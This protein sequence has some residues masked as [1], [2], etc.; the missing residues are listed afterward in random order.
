M[1][2]NRILQVIAPLL[3]AL[4]TS[5]RGDHFSASWLEDNLGIWQQDGVWS[6]SAYP[7]NGHFI[8]DSN[9][10]PVPGPNPTYDVVLGIS[11]PCT[12]TAN[13]QIQT[14]NV[15][16]GATLNLGNQGYLW[17]NTGFGNAGLI[18]LNSTG[19]FSGLLRASANSNVVNGGIIFMSD[20]FSNSVTAGSTGKV[21]TI[22]P[23]GTIRGAGAINEYHGDDRRTFFQIVNHGLI[24][25]MQP[26]NALRVQLTNDPAFAV[27]MINDGTLRATGP[28]V[29][30]ISTLGTLENVSNDGGII[31]AIDTGTVRLKLDATVTGGTLATSGNGTIRGDFPNSSGGTFNNVLNTGIMAVGDR[32]N[33][34]IAGTFTN[35]GVV[36][37]DGA[38]ELS[39][40]L[41][42]RGNSVT[43]T[44]TGLIA[45][46]G[47]CGIGGGDTV[48]QTAIISPGFT[49]RGRGTIGTDN[50]LYL[51]KALNVVNQGLIDATGPLTIFVRADQNSQL[52]NDG[53]T[54]RASNGGVLNFNCG[55]SGGLVLNS[56]GTVEALAGST[57]RVNDL[58]TL[59]G[60]TITTSGTGVIRGGVP[61]RGG[62]LKNVTSTGTVAI[63]P[64]EFLHLADTFTNNG[65]VRF[66]GTPAGGASLLLRNDVT[67]AGTGVF[68]MDGQQAGIAG[69]DVVGRTMTVAPA[70][71]IRGGGTIGVFNSNFA[72]KILNVVNQGLIE[73]TTGL[74]IFVRDNQGSNV[75]NNA[76]TLRAAPGSVLEF[77][78]AGTVANNNGGIVEALSN[79]TIQF[80]NGAA[81]INNAG[82]TIGLNG[83]TI[84]AA[85][86][87]DL[88]GGQLIGNGTF[89]GPI[90][91]NGGSVAPGFSA[92]KI[93]INGNYTQGANGVLNM[94]IGG[95][96]PGTGY[97]QLQVSG[98]A[99]LGGTLN[100]TLINGFQP[101]VGDVFQIIAPNAFSGAFAT[102]NTVGFSGTVTYSS[103][104][105]TLTVNSSAGFP[106]NI[107]TRMHVGTDP[108]QL[109]G[110]FI[111]T[112]SEPKK[113]I[114]LATGP[115]LAAF[116][117]S[118]FLADPVLELYQGNNLIASN[119]NWKIPAQAE[120]EATGVKP[121]DDV[122][123]A[124][125]RT[126]APGA[127]TAVVRGTSGGTGV[128]TVQI[129][130]LAQTSNSKLANISSRGFVQTADDR[131]MIAGFI[132]GG[133]GGGN[134]GIV[135]RA[136]APSLSGVIAG[137]LPDP[138]L[139]LKNAN[140]STL[141]FNDDW[142][143]SPQAND[144]SARGLAPSDSRES[145]LG[146]SLANGAYTAIVRGKGGETGVAVV[147][148]YNV[149]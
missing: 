75:A 106:L 100:V 45:M 90:R 76:G 89:T 59:E 14:L 44:G 38:A 103:S 2:T 70:A 88:D 96:A 39:T 108:N 46:N 114:V 77:N 13:V 36:R 97:D 62:T 82:G 68:A 50:S 137:V 104:G 84:N 32:E 140:G 110:G 111:I 20:H 101:A 69:I 30:H 72:H 80:I 63:G 147:E 33:F 105:I 7:N 34:G 81:F 52:T 117:I 119:D 54:L 71:I 144:I 17:A 98:T 130:D 139:E 73:A 18:T 99:T 116:G 1:K 94:E 86:G 83:G 146:V 19:N 126:L 21:L 129:Y 136:I 12:L 133:S 4:G 64:K 26:N 5:A 57:V 115:S 42:M 35:N 132:I 8:L 107:S 51:H 43:L 31:E 41:V 23:G 66:E 16:Q 58:V 128:G 60:G 24:E 15:L 78:G 121:S 124:L 65:L 79:S 142:Q 37:L 49:I 131:V 102:I 3:I 11:D 138:T 148:V 149:D 22:S 91:N 120:I 134:S 40:G 85:A 113:V 25:A 141:V 122:E 74:T 55:F 48:G 145:A 61:E 67:L 56:G 135:V 109:I 6:T 112:G 27:A 125:V 9:N 127:Y 143:Q 29:L 95:T 123:S 10:N 53:G 87:V 118:G 92:G 93:T 47:G 28:G